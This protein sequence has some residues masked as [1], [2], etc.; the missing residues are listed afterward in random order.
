VTTVPS[1]LTAPQLRFVWEAVHDRYTRQAADV[2]VHSITFTGLT[3]P[4]R[5]AL[6]GLLGRSRLPGVTVMV[7]MDQLDRRLLD[8][9]AAMTARHVAEL[10]HGPIVNRPAQRRAARQ[11]RE[12]MW[13]Q[14]EHA[15]DPRL[16]GWIHHLRA[17]GTATRVARAAAVAT[18]QLVAEALAVAELLPADG[19]ALPRLAERATGDPH[20]LDRGRPLR[21]LLL[22]AALHMTDE[23]L[24]IPP[25]LVAQRAVLATVGVHLDSVSTDVLVLGL[26]AD[27]TGHVDRLANQAADAGEPLRL[28]LRMLQA[29]PPIIRPTSQPVSVCENPS[30]VEAAAARLGRPSSPLVCTDGIPTTA[31]LQLLASARRQGAIVRVSADFDAAGVRI[32]NLLAR[33]VSAIPWRYTADTYRQAVTARADRQRVRLTGQIPDVLLDPQLAAEM[34]R[35]RVAVYEEQQTDILLGDLRT[36]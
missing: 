29:A 12:W 33:Q 3:R 6:A 11:A 19:M 22:L 26:R 18:D 20:A 32:T 35:T 4:Q 2:P 17:S 13:D 30:V 28:T 1:A 34:R 21:T 9:D 15:V 36:D 16:A 5:D 10:L 25:S 24:L 31:V 7:R 8:S 14:L 27:G 23:P